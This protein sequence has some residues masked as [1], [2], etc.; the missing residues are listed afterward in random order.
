MRYKCKN[1]KYSFE[2]NYYY[3]SITRDEC[4]FPY[5]YKTNCS[6]YEE[7]YEDFEYEDFE[8]YIDYEDLDI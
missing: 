6:G 7:E 2:D 1:E 4:N 3:C 5:R 8:D